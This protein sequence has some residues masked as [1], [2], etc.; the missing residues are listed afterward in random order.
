M[1]FF[2]LWNVWQK[3]V[4]HLQMRINAFHWQLTPTVLLPSRSI[5]RTLTSSRIA[6]TSCCGRTRR[7]NSLNANIWPDEKI[8]TRKFHKKKL[9]DCERILFSIHWQLYYIEIFN[10][11]LP[12]QCLFRWQWFCRASQTLCPSLKIIDI[13]I[14]SHFCEKKN[15]ILQ[16]FVMLSFDLFHQFIKNLQKNSWNILLTINW[17]FF[18]WFAMNW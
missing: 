8:L 13:I 12:I 2:N 16:L 11:I 10:K 4:S 7:I 14:D 3:N 15:K 17:N 5:F 9:I 1:N 18:L 6:F